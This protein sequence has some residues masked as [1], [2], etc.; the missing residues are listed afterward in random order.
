MNK[1]LLVLLL[2]LLAFSERIMFDLGANYELIT[3][4]M[5]IA[6]IYLGAKESTL[7]VFLTL[8][9]SDLIIGNSSIFIFTWSGFLLPAILAHKFISN[10][11]LTKKLFSGTITG[12]ASVGFFYLWTNFGVWMTSSMYSKD[13]LGLMQSYI[14]ALPF[15]R[16]QAQ[17]A[18]YAIPM[19]IIL[20]EA[21]LYIGNKIKLRGLLNL[22]TN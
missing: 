2:F 16:N 3:S 11:N 14:N 12:A 20:T 19:L 17:S 22:K 15:L 18:I 6:S 9:F 1:K 10:E 7:I 4:V 21:S 5:I 8:F 13:I